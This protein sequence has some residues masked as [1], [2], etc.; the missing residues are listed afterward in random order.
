M[1]DRTDISRSSFDGALL[2]ACTQLDEIEQLRTLNAQ[3]NENLT[4]VQA[5][6]TELLEWYRKLK[7]FE[8]FALALERAQLLHP[9]G[10]DFLALFAEIEE[11]LREQRGSKR[12]QQELID[13]AVVAWRMCRGERRDER[14]ARIDVDVQARPKP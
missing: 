5:R 7:E 4:A 14:A 12:E 10:S 13:I 9:E 8:I 1:N 3:L 2:L 6:C 11:A